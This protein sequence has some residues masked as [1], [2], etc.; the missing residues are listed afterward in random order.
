M[1]IDIVNQIEHAED[2]NTLDRSSL[3]GDGF[4]TTGVIK[5]N[6]LL[7]KN[8]HLDRL[9]QSATKLLFPELDIGRLSNIID[10]LCLSH[11]S[12]IIRI[13]VYRRQT[14]RGYSIAKD[15]LTQIT[16]MLSP[17]QKKPSEYCELFDAKT[18]ISLNHSLAG[19]KHLNRLDSVLAASEVTQANHEALMYQQNNLICG[20]KS[21]I[22]L[23]LNKQWMTPSITSCGVNGIM[24]Q[25]VLHNMQ[26]IGIT[27]EIVD[28]PSAQI[29]DVS[30]AFI[31]NCVFGVWPASY[32][33]GREL[34]LLL[35]N[36]ITERFDSL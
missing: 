9:K 28:L 16:I 15:A 32:V 11:C 8:Q 2:P 6:Q 26:K 18:E 27:C 10:E 35:T 25:R 34:D 5:S 36:Q 33:N 21:N 4:F 20:S 29:K 30:A 19:I 14:K 12:A 23:R 3:F 17:V 31:T 24:R 1:Q 13:N 7:L 22:F